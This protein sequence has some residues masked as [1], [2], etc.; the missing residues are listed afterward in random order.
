MTIE[1]TI[2]D[3]TRV[4][5]DRLSCSKS[6]LALHGRSESHFDEMPPDAVAYP[7]TTEE[8]AEIVRV[9]RAHGCP[10]IG[11][12]AGTSLEG[13]VS[14]PRG[15]ISVDFSRMARVL[16]LRAEDM[17]VRV[18]PGLTREALNEELRDGGGLRCGSGHGLDA[19]TQSS[20]GN[21]PTTRIVITVFLI[22]QFDSSFIP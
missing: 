16:E 14:A 5:G 22:C 17:I 9:C 18:Q 4:L 7:E 3:L 20:W 19:S 12:G 11:F 2:A 8:V 15:G 10:V 13:H 6:D 21:H 1:T